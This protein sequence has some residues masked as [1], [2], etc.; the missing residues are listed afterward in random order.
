MAGSLQDQLLQAGLTN[1]KKVKQAQR[2]Q[3]KTA[4]QVRQGEEVVDEAKAAAE[5]AKLAKINKDKGL[6]LELSEKAKTKAISA[7]IKQLIESHALN[8]KGYEL[9]YNFTDGK[10]VKK[11][12]VNDLIQ[13]QLSRGILAISKLGTEYSVIPAV[14]ADK[15]RERNAQYIVSQVDV[16]E[17]DAVEEDDPYADYEIPDDLMW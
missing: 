13:H 4:K 3:K 2:H 16:S 14:I 17:L 9:D 15:I 1:K 6:N 7:Q 8:L 10:K 5:A 11:I 12:Y